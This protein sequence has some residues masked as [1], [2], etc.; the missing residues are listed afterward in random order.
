MEKE[1]GVILSQLVNSMKDLIVRLK[2]SYDKG[3]KIELENTKKEIII[4]QKKIDS[5]VK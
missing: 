4:L 1:E 3:N 5:L 2:K